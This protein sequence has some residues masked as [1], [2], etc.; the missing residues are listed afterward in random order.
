MKHYRQIFAL[1]CITGL[2]TTQSCKEQGC[3]LYAPEAD[4]FV[5]FKVND[6]LG[7]PIQKYYY[8]DSIQLYLA[9]N[10]TA[11]AKLDILPEYFVLLLNN[12]PPFPGDHDREF[13]FSWTTN[14]SDTLRIKY[15]VG[16]IPDGECLYTLEIEG[17]FF[18]GEEFSD[19]KIIKKTHP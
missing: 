14:D 11:I 10:P 7:L 5:V 9:N 1:L 2:F 17:F 6:T 8:N 12:F 18:N 3:G 13:I 15:K 19:L 16:E 4:L